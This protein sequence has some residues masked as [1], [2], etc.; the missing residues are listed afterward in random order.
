MTGYAPEEPRARKRPRTAAMSKNTPEET[1]E[2]VSIADD[3]LLDYITN[4]EIKDTPKER[5]RQRI[6][7]ALFHEYGLSVE[8]MEPDFSIPVE[9]G[10][11]VRRRSVEIAIFQHGQ[12]HDLAHLTR[13][14]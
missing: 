11:K 2:V 3:I 10:G 5:V 4:K 6:A 12:S 13:V 14:V 8:D 9:L 1:A 7:R